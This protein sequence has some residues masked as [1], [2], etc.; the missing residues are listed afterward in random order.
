MMAMQCL[1]ES[2][3]EI[4]QRWKRECPTLMFLPATS[5]LNFSEVMAVSW[6]LG[7]MILDDNLTSSYAFHFQ[8]LGPGMSLIKHMEPIWFCNWH[9]LKT[10]WFARLWQA[11]RWR[12][13]LCIAL[14]GR[15]TSALQVTWKCA[16]RIWNFCCLTDSFWPQFVIEVHKL[17]LQR[18]QTQTTTA[19]VGKWASREI[20]AKRRAQKTTMC[21]ADVPAFWALPRWLIK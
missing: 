6:F 20:T 21:R 17:Q 18:L 11:K 4:H 10:S 16:S 3:L 2:V 7:W 1:A 15:L 5:M 13:C 14:L 12:K 8:F 19:S 9:L